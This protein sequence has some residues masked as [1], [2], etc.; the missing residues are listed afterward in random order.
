MWALISKMQGCIYEVS[1]PTLL[2][3]PT[4]LPPY[5]AGVMDNTSALGMAF[6]GGAKKM[7][8]ATEDNASR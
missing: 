8:K 6:G 5:L 4:F 7:Q 1:R 3:A 2:T